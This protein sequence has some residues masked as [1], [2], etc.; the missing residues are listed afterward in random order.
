MIERLSVPIDTKTGKIAENAMRDSTKSKLIA[1]LDGSTLT[2]RVSSNAPDDGSAAA[3]VGVL[4][5]VIGSAAVLMAKSRGYSDRAAELLR[6]TEQEK[7]LLMPPT[8]KV[9][10]KYDLFGG[11]WADEIALAVT[12][13]SITA[14]HVMAMQRV[15]AEPAK[16]PAPVEGA[17]A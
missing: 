2:A 8:L 12:V 15:D 13:G 16:S 7:A 17:A 11:K 3:I 9:L 14:A 6:Y 10:A 5:D 1:A 4:Y